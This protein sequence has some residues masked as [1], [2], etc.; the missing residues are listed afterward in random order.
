VFPVKYDLNVYIEATIT[1][2]NC[3]KENIKENE[4]L[5]VGPRWAPDTKSDWPI[6]CRS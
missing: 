1:N 5:V 3:L 6:D 2:R 4:K